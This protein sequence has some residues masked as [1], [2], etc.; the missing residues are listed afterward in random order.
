[1]LHQALKDPS[2]SVRVIAAQALSQF[3][4]P[5]DIE[6]GVAVLVR[7]ARLDTN[8]IYV[9]MLALNALDSLDERAA[10]ARDAIADL[11][12]QDDAVGQRMR[13]YVDRLLTKTLTDLDAG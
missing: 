13:N 4:S 11:P 3:G 1:L 7:A 8:G 10:S 6:S 5:D 12:R 9:S 2:P